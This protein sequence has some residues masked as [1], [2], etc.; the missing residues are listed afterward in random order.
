MSGRSLLFAAALLC[1]APACTDAD[2]TSTGWSEINER[3]N[4][5]RAQL[6][7]LQRVDALA[8]LYV[9]HELRRDE[10]LALGAKNEALVIDALVARPDFKTRF[11]GRVAEFMEA[12]GKK[13][14]SQSLDAAKPLADAFAG[15]AEKK[16]AEAQRFARWLV[17]ELA[18]R[19]A[20]EVLAKH[21][22]AFAQMTYRELL[23]VIRSASAERR[24][25]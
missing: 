4:A 7:R 18:P 8:R 12:N 20:D 1:L 25:G 6:A 21:D 22:A 3:T 23:D 9:G 14:T 19:V 10:L 17:R 16:K 24:T 13:P 5:R 15:S 2:S 11:S